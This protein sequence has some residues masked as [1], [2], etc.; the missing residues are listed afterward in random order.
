MAKKKCV[1]VDLIVCEVQKGFAMTLPSI[2][3]KFSCMSTI[4]VA[5]TMLQLTNTNPELVLVTK[6]L[7]ML[8]YD[9]YI[10]KLTL[11]LRK[12]FDS[13]LMLLL[14]K[15]KND[16]RSSFRFVSKFEIKVLFSQ[17]F[18]LTGTTPAAKSIEHLNHPIPVAPLVNKFLVML[19][20]DP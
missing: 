20:E 9:S 18:S 4:P 17:S 10:I 13:L 6:L 12:M 2:P 3:Q 15:L 1:S 8:K 5:K 16:W 7:M 19:R 14:M 11:I